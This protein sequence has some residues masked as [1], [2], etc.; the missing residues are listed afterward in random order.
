MKISLLLPTRKRPEMFTKMYESAFA[1][2]SDPNN[3][4]V[5]A[6]IDDDD[7]SYDDIEFKQLIKVRGRRI[8]LSEMW[9]RCWAEATG[10][11][12]GHIGDDVIF[13]TQGW[14]K[15]ITSAFPEDRIAF[16][17]GLDGSDQDKIGFGT[18]GFIHK[19]WTDTV[20]YFVPPY[21]S[22]D[23]ND[24]WL[25]EV[26]DKIDR[27]AVVKDVLIEHMHPA[28]KKRETDETDRERMARGST[29]NVESIYKTKSSERERDADKL[30]EAIR[31]F[32]V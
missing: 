7:D 21:F 4:E 11:V 12:F 28:W 25:N 15:K 2:A 32:A 29:D 1:T 26:A 6:Y 17:H 5:V 8:V 3:I 18:H 9:N 23:Y 20:G 22:C 31:G 13:K 14:D 30:T 10:E 19:R 24:T 16:V 27:H